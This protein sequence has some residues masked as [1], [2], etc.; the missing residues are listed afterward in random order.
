MR[1]SITIARHFLRMLRRSFIPAAIQREA[2][3]SM[4]GAR[5][6]PGRH[7]RPQRGGGKGGLGLMGRGEQVQQLINDWLKKAYPRVPGD[8]DCVADTPIEIKM[9]PS[10]DL[11]EYNIN[12]GGWSQFLWNC[13]VQWRQIIDSAQEG[14]LLIGA[15]EQ[16]KALSMLRALCARDDRECEDAMARAAVGDGTSIFSEF[17][18]RSYGGPANEWQSLFYY[19][20][21]VY[22]KRLE[23]LAANESRVRKAVGAF[24]A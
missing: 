15:A 12:N 24:D 3:A 5:D 7:R 14:Y 17:N 13:F 11:I 20:S 1:Q 6:L 23:W 10:F 21:G 16:S 19:D 4:A 18:R 8:F 9:I 2:S 22:E